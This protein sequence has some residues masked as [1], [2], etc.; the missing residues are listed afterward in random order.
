MGC[1]AINFYIEDVSATCECMIW[2]L[3]LSLVLRCALVIYRDMVGVGVVVL[4]C[5]S[6][7]YAELLAVASCES[8]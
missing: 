7:K 3:N 4:V 8:S 1:V 6:R 2:C 5:N